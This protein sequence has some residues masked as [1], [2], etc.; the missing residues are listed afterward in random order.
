MEEGPHSYRVR[1]DQLD[2][3]PAI[4]QKGVLTLCLPLNLNRPGFAGGHLV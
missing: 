2:D 1:L 3:V 4:R